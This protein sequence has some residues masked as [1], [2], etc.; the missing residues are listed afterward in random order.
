MGGMIVKFINWML[1]KNSHIRNFRSVRYRVNRENTT[2]TADPST[3][4]F[5]IKR[6]SCNDTTLTRTNNTQQLWPT[7]TAE[8][9]NLMKTDYL[10]TFNSMMEKTSPIK[11]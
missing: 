9:K 6:N 2:H 10:Q 4:N 5:R 7:M 3:I 11:F 8:F 1:G